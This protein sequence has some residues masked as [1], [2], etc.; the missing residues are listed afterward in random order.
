MTNYLLYLYFKNKFTFKI[1]KLNYYDS[2][3]VWYSNYPF[4]FSFC[5]EF[6]SEIELNN[7]F[8]LCLK[9]NQSYTLNT[10]YLAELLPADKI[11]QF[12]IFAMWIWF[13]SDVKKSHITFFDRSWR[14]ILN[15][16]W[17]STK[18]IPD[19]LCFRLVHDVGTNVSKV[20][21]VNV[22]SYLLC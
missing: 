19:S 16:F 18:F 6:W 4:F 22:I 3:N 14:R 21:L 5:E 9:I 13:V 20:I 11:V 15:S 17:F 10:R 12:V 2:E 1:W 8:K 7:S